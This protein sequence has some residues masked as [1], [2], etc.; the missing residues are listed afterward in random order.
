MSDDEPATEA[1]QEPDE[2]VPDE[3]DAAR[4]RGPA[5]GAVPGT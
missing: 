1:A 2:A 4:R 5:A 3:G